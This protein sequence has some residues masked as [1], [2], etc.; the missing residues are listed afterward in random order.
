MVSGED[1]IMAKENVTKFIEK[2]DAD[3]ELVKKIN[4]LLAD[5]SSEDEVAEKLAA[6]K[7]GLSDDEVEEIVRVTAELQAFQ[8]EGESEEALKAYAKHPAHVA[9]ADTKVR[10]YTIQRSCLDF[11]I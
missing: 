2:I 6:F 7:S 1:K 10:P 5:V 8:E 4:E 3:E 9:V 11:E